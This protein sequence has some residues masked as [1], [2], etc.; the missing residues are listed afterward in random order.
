MNKEIGE[1][2]Q[3]W[4]EQYQLGISLSQV[5]HGVLKFSTL[6]SSTPPLLLSTCVS[7]AAGH[8]ISGHYTNFILH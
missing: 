5:I 8:L 2:V 7:P 6:L 1:K 3:I 4:R